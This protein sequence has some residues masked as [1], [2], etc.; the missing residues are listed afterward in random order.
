[1]AAI[2]QSGCD[3][4]ILPCPYGHS[5][6]AIGANSVGPVIDALLSHCG[7][8]ILAVRMPFEPVAPMFE[9]VRMLITAESGATLLAASWAAGL[10]VPRGT[11]RLVLVLQREFRQRIQALVKSATPDVQ[12]DPE[13]LAEAMIDDHVRLHQSLQR[14][15]STGAFRYELDMRQE[16]KSATIPLVP[17]NEHPLLVLPMDRSYHPSHPTILDRIRVCPSPVLVVAE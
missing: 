1:L 5:L 6:E 7:V 4:L 14:T 8:P 17:E 3:L 11:L 10:V 2:E 9:Q 13:T 12:L 16:D 15:A